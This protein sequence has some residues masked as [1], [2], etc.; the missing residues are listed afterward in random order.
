MTPGQLSSELIV[1]D[2]TQEGKSWDQY[3]LCVQRHTKEGGVQPRNKMFQ[4]YQE[5]HTICVCEGFIMSFGKQLSRHPKAV[6]LNI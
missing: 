3:V 5:L 1:S 4:A 6:L 2:Y